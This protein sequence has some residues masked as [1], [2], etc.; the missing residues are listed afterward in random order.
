MLTAQASFV[1]VLPWVLIGVLVLFFI[2]PT[3]L[4]QRRASA[5]TP[6]DVAEDDSPRRKAGRSRRR[7][8]G[9][10]QLAILA[11]AIALFIALRQQ[12]SA[13]RQRFDV[14]EAAANSVLT[15]LQ[16]E[17]PDFRNAYTYRDR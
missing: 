11:G 16:R 14:E 1:S 15:D 7:I 5:S 3:A 8:Y 9:Y 2:L 12:D 6:T 13:R 4:A 10:L 17:D